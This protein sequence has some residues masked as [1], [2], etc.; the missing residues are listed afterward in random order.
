[1][2]KQRTWKGAGSQCLVWRHNAEG[3]TVYG[4]RV[5]A[6]GHNKYVSL[7][8][9]DIKVAK[10]KLW[11]VIDREMAKPKRKSKDVPRVE[12]FLPEIMNTLKF[13]NQRSST[14][15]SYEHSF[16]QLLRSAPK[17]FP[18][19]KVDKI[20][21]DDLSGWLE[22]VFCAG[23]LCEGRGFKLNT[24][25]QQWVALRIMFDRAVD[26]RLIG[27]KPR[28]KLNHKTLEARQLE[29]RS[30]RGEPTRKPVPV[31][32]QFEELVADIRRF[33]GKFPEKQDRAANWVMFLGATGLRIGEAQ[34]LK[35]HHVDLENSLLDLR[36]V[37]LKN[38]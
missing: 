26:E 17:R 27:G 13:G 6:G 2:K 8:T 38:Q 22:T 14:V 3:E 19:L 24:I 20:T 16:N 32:L 1:M 23:R 7:E 29:W 28:F 9:S 25:K 5:T 33:K 37:R 31:G 36:G 21:N 34:R 11:E 35:W 18:R 15:R 4:A 12:D 30:Q 10:R